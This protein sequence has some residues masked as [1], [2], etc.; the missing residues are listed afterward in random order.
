MDGFHMQGANSVV[1]CLGVFLNVI[2]HTVIQTKNYFCNPKTTLT[3]L[4][5]KNSK[6]SFNVISVT[7]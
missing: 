1:F 4:S 6:Y 5:L 7:F 2:A 3:R